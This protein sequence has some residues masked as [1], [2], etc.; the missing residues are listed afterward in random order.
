MDKQAPPRAPRLIPASFF[1]I[2][3]GLTGLGNDWRA[4]TAAWGLP[5]AVGE[6]I[7]LLGAICWVVIVAMY[8]WKWVAAPAQAR[9]ETNNPVQCCFIGLA[10]V[11][12]ML[13]AWSVLPYSRPAAI[14]LYLPGAAFTI[15]FALWRMGHLWRGGRDPSATTAVLYLPMGA[16][17]FVTG[18]VAGA[19][20]WTEFGQLA[21]GAGL[22]T[23]L[24]VESVLLHRLYTATPM[25]AALRPT[26]GIQLAPPAV[27]ALCYISVAGMH[28]DV[29][30][31]MLV[32]YAL[33]QALLL[34]RMVRWLREAPFAA[35]YWAYTFGG[36][37]LA[38]VTIRLS[39][40]NPGLAFAVLAPV[41]FVLANILVL[42]IAAATLMSMAQGKLLPP[43]PPIAPAP[44]VESNRTTPA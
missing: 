28:S 14:A 23:W 24:A 32:G 26:M 4:A 2:V 35:S 9:E 15:L 17:G 16:G 38:G 39:P 41:L 13:V 34:I 29:F 3:L 11:A 43:A 6:A 1:G 25:P 33:L 8:V 31:H 7:H 36:T 42:V 22:F 18:I 40:G 5:A 21:F 37:A 30:A 10:G 44:P 19:L 12:T 27:G 20:G